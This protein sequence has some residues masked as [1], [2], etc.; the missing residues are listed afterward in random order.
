MNEKIYYKS[1]LSSIEILSY[2]RNIKIKYIVFI[3]M[4]EKK[5]NF[6]NS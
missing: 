5:F 1:L 6:F 4:R 3:L 2:A